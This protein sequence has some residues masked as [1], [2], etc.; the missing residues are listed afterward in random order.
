MPK[1][2]S[3][4]ESATGWFF[5]PEAWGYPAIIVWI[6]ELWTESRD[7]NWDWKF[8]DF[9]DIRVV[10][11]TE[12]EQEI[13]DTE[14]EELTWEKE[15]RI[16]LIGA[17]YNSVISDKSNLWKLITA[18][19]DVKSVKDIKD[20]SLDQLLWLKCYI[21]IEHVGKDW[22]YE[23][24]KSVSWANKKMPVHEQVR[25]NFY[26]WMED[27]NDFDLDL[28]EDKE[29]LKPWDIDR[30]KKTPEF[31]AIAKELGIVVEK[32]LDEQ[33]KDIQKE[34][35]EK[36]AE[37]E[38]ANNEET[39]SEDEAKWIFKWEVED[40]DIIKDEPK[41]TTDARDESKIVEEKKEKTPEEVKKKTAFE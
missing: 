10:F 26:F 13:Y 34:I 24:I 29:A 1:K 40:E 8:R 23:K 5:K 30:I 19:Y 37:Q 6:M 32:S 35:G 4:K 33:D 15:D 31:K 3:Y 14:K 38:K 22:A 41:T 18:V 21:D 11:E 17:N 27:S 20:F 2:V 7:F 36:K 9:E 25:E 39:V 28:C 16:W 12:A